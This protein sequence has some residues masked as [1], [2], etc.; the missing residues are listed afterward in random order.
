MTSPSRNLNV[1]GPN[2]RRTNQQVTLLPGRL[3]KCCLSKEDKVELHIICGKRT[4][5]GGKRQVQILGSEHKGEST[6]LAQG[7]ISGFPYGLP[8]TTWNVL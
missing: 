2:L 5:G 1:G 8:S 7:S 6:G 3:A 4:V